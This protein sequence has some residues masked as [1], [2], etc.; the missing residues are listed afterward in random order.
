M[1]VFLREAGQNGRNGGIAVGSLSDL[2][3]FARPV[4]APAIRQAEEVA[5]GVG[6]QRAGRT[7][8]RGAERRQRRRCGGVATSG[9][10]DL[11]NRAGVWAR[12]RKGYAE[13]IAIGIDHQ[14]VRRG[15]RVELG[16]RGRRAGVA[17]GRL[18]QFEDRGVERTVFR[19]PEEI[20]GGIHDKLV[21]R[22]DAGAAVETGEDRRRRCVAAV[23]FGE[24]ED[25]AV[26]ARAALHRNAEEIA[27]CVGDETALRQLAIGAVEAG[28]NCRR[29]G[30]TAAVMG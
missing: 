7:S 18:G 1:I 14:W 30:V 6:Y 2:E 3:Y 25:R 10:R 17:A 22:A 8:V 16:E 15:W 13:E 19:D 20:A 29:A 23:R 9:L 21:R 5:G 11:K 24:L 28:Q 26:T 12:A 27:R 4:C